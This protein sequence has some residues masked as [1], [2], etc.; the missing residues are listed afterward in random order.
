MYPVHYFFLLHSK[1]IPLF[2]KQSAHTMLRI[3]P[4]KLAKAKVNYLALKAK[5]KVTTPDAPFLSALLAIPDWRIV[6][7]KMVMDN[8]EVCKFT[9]PLC[10][11]RVGQLL[12]FPTGMEFCT[13]FSS[14][15]ALIKPLL[16]WC[17]KLEANRPKDPPV[18]TLP[19]PTVAARVG[20]SSSASAPVAALPACKIW[21][22][23]P[24]TPPSQVSGRD[25]DP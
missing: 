14:R 11:C 2:P 16:D 9:A 4:S 3:S 21:L 6:V 5:E 19:S 12:T 17:Y 1:P 20:N 15:Y 13:H 25:P 22:V 10:S 23:S 24:D 8:A 18:P 7:D